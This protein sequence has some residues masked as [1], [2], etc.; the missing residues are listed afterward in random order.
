[1]SVS[2]TVTALFPNCEFGGIVAQQV[3]LAVNRLWIQLSV[4]S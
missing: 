2:D 1:V 3:G 4:E